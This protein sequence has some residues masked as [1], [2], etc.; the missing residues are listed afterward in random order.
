MKE[1]A[2]SA[3]FSAALVLQP[4]TL[5]HYSLS[6]HPPLWPCKGM[7]STH[8]WQFTTYCKLGFVQSPTHRIISR[9]SISDSGYGK[10]AP[11]LSRHLALEIM[12]KV[13]ARDIVQSA[14]DS[15]TPPGQ[16]HK[17]EHERRRGDGEGEMPSSPCR[18]ALCSVHFGQIKPKLAEKI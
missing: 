10:T 6:I 16:L 15:I 12:S 9:T 13:L 14:D 2:F 3:L 11:T 17:K 7:S 18:V 8:W 5:N 1:T 4:I